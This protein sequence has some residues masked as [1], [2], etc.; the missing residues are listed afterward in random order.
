MRIER[1]G[2]KVT[3]LAE[4]RID[5]NNAPLFASEI[6]EA[7]KGATEF[8]LDFSDLEYI[9]SS[10]LRVIMLAVKTMRRQGNMRIVNASEDIYELLEA[11]RFTG[12]CDIE[13][14]E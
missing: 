5:T 7:L 13:M 1:D 2:S 14:K 10:G 4:G 3:M 8:I 6:E 11:T 9:S 12:I